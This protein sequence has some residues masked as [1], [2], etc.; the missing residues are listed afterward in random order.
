MEEQGKIAQQDKIDLINKLV[1]DYKVNGNVKS[2]EEVI[3]MFKP[4]L[5][6]MCE[7]Y[8]KLFPNVHEWATIEQEAMVIFYQL[9]NEYTIG[10]V[11][12][13][14]VFIMKKLPFRLRYFFIKEIKHRTKNLCHEESQLLQYNKA[15]EV[16]ILDDML[17]DMEDR[18]HI[19]MIKEL[20]QSDL[21]SD[22]DRDMLLMNIN[23]ISHEKIAEKYG[24]SRSR[25]T[26]ILGGIIKKIRKEIDD[27]ERF[28]RGE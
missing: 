2:G 13:F 24:I 12:Y 21:L 25:V 8:N 26:K 22:R 4:F 5:L 7:K 10:G 15:E 20:I 16:D 14:N 1:E 3:K 28:N 9:M 19:R 17:T 23:G 6:K 18:E 11:A 27:Y